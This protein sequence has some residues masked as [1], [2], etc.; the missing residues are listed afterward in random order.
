[1]HRVATHCVG[2]WV[3]VAFG[4]PILLGWAAL[5]VMV[6]TNDEGGNVMAPLIAVAVLLLPLGLAL[7]IKGWRARHVRV[8]L[9]ESGI[10]FVDGPS[11]WSVP[12]AKVQRFQAAPDGTSAIIHAP[13][14][15]AIVIDHRYPDYLAFIQALVQTR[16]TAF[17]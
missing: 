12:W 13:F 17:G 3:Q 7:T 2:G 10:V 9:H 6:I 16:A 1:M 4:V 11:R 8:D 5:S 14:V 15:P